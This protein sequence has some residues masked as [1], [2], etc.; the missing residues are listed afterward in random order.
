MTERLTSETEAGVN[1]AK[2]QEA[3]GDGKK[4]GMTRVHRWRARGAQR[5][6]HVPDGRSGARGLRV[7]PRT[8]ASS[9]W[10]EQRCGGRGAGAKSSMPA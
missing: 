3:E 7:R 1:N 2:G 10:L 6:W 9:P 8:T 5:R 4:R